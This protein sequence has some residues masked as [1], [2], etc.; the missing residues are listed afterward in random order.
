[1][2]GWFCGV[3]T[4][5]GDEGLITVSA[6]KKIK[7]CQVVVL[8]NKEKSCCAAFQ[9]ARKTVPSI[10]EK[11]LLF[12]ELPMTK[13]VELLEKAQIGLAEEI[14]LLLKQEKKIVF[15][16]LGDPA[17]YSTFEYVREKVKALGFEVESISGVTSFCAAAS[18]LGIS[19]SDRDQMLHVVPASYD[20]LKA[21]DLTGTVVFMKSGK[22]LSELKKLIQEKSSDY[23][24]D[25]YA[26]SNVGM[27]DQV[28][29][30]S[31]A[32]F[33][34]NSGYFTLVILKNLQK[35]T[36][37]SHRFFQNRSCKYFPCHKNID[38]KDFNCL[39]CYCPLYFKGTEC[40]GN[41]VIK[42]NGVKSCINCTVPHH[43][44]NY[45]LINEKLK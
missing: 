3:G 39:F 16:T 9:I 6:V 43:R 30:K 32:D 41:F 42:E 45:D 4:G 20:P 21:F 31:L 12:R 23:D 44:E 11:Q 33:D 19:L 8:P 17:V 35:K 29:C 10:E 7:E 13:D 5:P 24:F 18:A 28:L 34:E 1:M 15:L 22:K 38:E 27:Q 36:Q 2:K 14:S 37:E 40:G 26:A 25:F